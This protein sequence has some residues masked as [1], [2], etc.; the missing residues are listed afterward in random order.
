MVL[1]SASG[2]AWDI[3]K[4]NGDMTVNQ[5][6]AAN[7]VLAHKGQPTFGPAELIENEIA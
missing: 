5:P 3:P 4:V 7:R 6:A 2:K 1:I